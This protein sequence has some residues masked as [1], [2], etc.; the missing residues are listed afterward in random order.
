MMGFPE[1]LNWVGDRLGKLVGPGPLP[2]VSEEEKRELEQTKLDSRNAI[3]K[4]NA[5]VDHWWERS[6]EESWR[7]RKHH[8]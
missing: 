8:A 5:S 2:P 6:I 3:K 1:M 7:P 4:V